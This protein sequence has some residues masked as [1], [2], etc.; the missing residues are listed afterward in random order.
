MYTLV[1]WKVV[2][3]SPY[4]FDTYTGKI[5]QITITANY[6][7]MS[8]YCHNFH[9]HS[10]GIASIQYNQ[11]FEDVDHPFPVSMKIDG[12]S[13]G[14]GLLQARSPPDFTFNMS[15]VYEHVLSLFH[16]N[17]YYQLYSCPVK[18]GFRSNLT[19]VEFLKPDRHGIKFDYK[20][21]VR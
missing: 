8:Q 7:Q 14:T 10:K 19:K 5:L 21:T 3:Y 11:Y 20:L 12:K 4:I 9:L 17:S 16:F 1:D 18:C 2:T 15:V 6:W 13:P